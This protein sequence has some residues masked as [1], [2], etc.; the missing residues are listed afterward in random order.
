MTAVQPIEI[1]GRSSEGWVGTRGGLGGKKSLRG[2][3]R[4]GAKKNPTSKTGTILPILS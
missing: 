1:R 4:I 3:Q 2:G